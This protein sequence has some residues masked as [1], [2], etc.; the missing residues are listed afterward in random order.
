MTVPSD[1][2]ENTLRFIAVNN[3]LLWHFG[4]RADSRIGSAAEAGCGWMYIPATQEEEY[5]ML[6]VLDQLRREILRCDV[7][8]VACLFG[9]SDICPSF[10]PVL[11]VQVAW[12]QILAQA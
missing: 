11:R 10:G 3:L 1:M 7:Q 12:G 5:R 6:T 2:F 9:R 4:R 8:L